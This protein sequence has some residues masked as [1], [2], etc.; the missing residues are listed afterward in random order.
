MAT[1]MT[2]REKIE[3]ALNLQRKA[4]EEAA[5]GRE[6]NASLLQKEAAKLVDEALKQE[7][8]SEES[9]RQYDAC[10]RLQRCGV[11]VGRAG[12]MRVAD[13]AHYLII[14]VE[15]AEWLADLLEQ[16]QTAVEKV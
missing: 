6:Y 2:T 8:W 16:M 10:T 13:N 12:G 9:K 5:A 14:P 11:K 7:L 3:G 4:T 15:G 1:Q